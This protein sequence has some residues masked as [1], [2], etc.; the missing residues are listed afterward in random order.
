MPF[1]VVAVAVA[2]LVAGTIARRLSRDVLRM[3]DDAV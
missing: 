3:G 2:V 1:V